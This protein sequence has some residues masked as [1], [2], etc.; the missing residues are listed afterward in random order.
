ML[1]GRVLR[2]IY[3]HARIRAIDMSAAR[4]VDGVMAVID[5]LA[6]KERTA[7]Y[8]GGPLVAVAAADWGADDDCRR[9]E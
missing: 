2:S 3:L 4:A 7:R 9:G 8:V 5:V 6:D 1:T